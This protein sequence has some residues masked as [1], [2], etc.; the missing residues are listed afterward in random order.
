MTELGGL[1]ELVVDDS[2]GYVM[3]DADRGY[4]SHE[5]G[6]VIAEDSSSLRVFQDAV[7]ARKVM[8]M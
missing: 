2:E 7:A 5:I 3:L 4:V 6:A 8:V 1:E